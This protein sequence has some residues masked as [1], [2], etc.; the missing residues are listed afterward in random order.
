MKKDTRWYIS[1]VLSVLLF[2]FVPWFKLL[3]LFATVLH[4]PVFIYGIIEIQNCFFC[5]AHC[6]NR[7]KS[8]EC[9]LTF[10]DGPDPQFTPRIL[11]LL[12]K[13]NFKATFFVVA[14]KARMY[15]EIVRECLMRG[16]CIACH[17]LD[18]K[19]TSNFRRYKGLKRDIGEAQRIIAEITGKKPLLYRPPVGLTNPHLRKALKDLNMECIGWSSSVRD[20]GNRFPKTFA[21]LPEL[22]RP[23]SVILLH[24]TLP[25]NNSSGLFLEYLEKLF[26]GIQDKGL[27][28]VTVDSLFELAA[29]HK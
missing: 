23:G 1:F 29:Y 4:I 6:H 7:K 24:D 27:R 26:I 10:D 18:H 13:Y 8:G 19:L 17:D 28:P 5:N 3:F 9:S 12:D 14:G 20:G 2:I 16:H 25:V 11:D 15:P 21:H 22:A